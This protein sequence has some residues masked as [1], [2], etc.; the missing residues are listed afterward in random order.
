MMNKV[1]WVEEGELGDQGAKFRR[2][3]VTGIQRRNNY[4]HYSQL[5]FFN[6]MRIFLFFSIT[7][8]NFK[9]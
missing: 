8:S 7:V 4:L 6:H 1:E 9:Y 3:F 5:V 2:F